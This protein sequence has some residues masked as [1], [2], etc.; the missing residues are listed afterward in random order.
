MLEDAGFAD[1]ESLGATGF[2]SS[3]TTMGMLFKG[4]KP[5]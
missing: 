2:A 4:V 3:A 1:V 5:H